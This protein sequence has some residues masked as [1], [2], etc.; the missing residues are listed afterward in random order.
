MLA[1]LPVPLVLLGLAFEA[2]HQLPLLLEQLMNLVIQALIL[3]RQKVQAH[4]LDLA[5][6][7]LCIGPV[8]RCVLSPTFSRVVE[9]GD[10]RVRRRH[11]A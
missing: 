7:R 3:T 6:H 8:G 2:L 9:G 4:A 1:P 5:T 11:L 10:L